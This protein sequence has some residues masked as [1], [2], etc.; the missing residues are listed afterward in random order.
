MN[1][2][3]EESTLDSA[4][5]DSDQRR[6]QRT[7]GPNLYSYNISTYVCMCYFS[8][9]SNSNKAELPKFNTPKLPF[10]NPRPSTS[11]EEG[12]AVGSATQRDSPFVKQLDL[13]RWKLERGKSFFLSCRHGCPPKKSIMSFTCWGIFWFLFPVAFFFVGIF[14]RIST[15]IAPSLGIVDFSRCHGCC[16]YLGMYLKTDPAGSLFQTASK[17]RF[18]PRR[19]HLFPARR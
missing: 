17:G 2:F 10:F 14:L 8:M 11:L 13:N 6:I 4:K 5:G 19:C 7:R 12:G 15:S 18:T 16:W 3:F 1:P 9:K